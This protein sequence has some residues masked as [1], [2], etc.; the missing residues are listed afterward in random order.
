[1]S[2]N[3]YE[4]PAAALAIPEAPGLGEILP[5]WERLRIYY[6]GILF[7]ETAL[8]A[9]VMLGTR[10]L[11][12]DRL[13]A[14]ALIG[15]AGANVCFC[16]GPCAEFYLNRVGLGGRASRLILFWAGTGL[17]FLLVIVALLSPLFPGM[18]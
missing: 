2:E 7:L 8:V 16:A 14:A 12:N 1:M 13:I 18:D 4:S 5:A 10:G 3:P 11:L 9:L 6:N 17:S 15:T